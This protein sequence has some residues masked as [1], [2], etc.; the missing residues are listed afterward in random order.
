MAYEDGLRLGG[1]A[2]L[3]DELAEG[4]VAICEHSTGGCCTGGA[5]A[6]MATKEC[7]H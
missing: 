7:E 1:L 4:G 6:S 5:S 2:G 3:A